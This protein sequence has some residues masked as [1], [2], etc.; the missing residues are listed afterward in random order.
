MPNVFIWIYS[1]IGGVKFIKHFKGVQAIEVWE[2]M[3]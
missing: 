3:G 1:G 2:L